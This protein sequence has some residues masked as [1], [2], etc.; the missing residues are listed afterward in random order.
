[1]DRRLAT[2]AA[3]RTGWHPLRR[4]CTALCRKG[5]CLPAT[6]DDVRRERAQAAYWTPWVAPTGN[7][8]LM[9]MHALFLMALLISGEEI[10]HADHG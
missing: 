7:A 9:D 6:T 5:L 8:S 4:C 3:A 10:L 1:M 2:T